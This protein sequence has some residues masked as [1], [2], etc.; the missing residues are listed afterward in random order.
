MNTYTDVQQVSTKLK[1]PVVRR[2]RIL[3]PDQDAQRSSMELGPSSSVRAFVQTVF[4]PTLAEAK[5]ASRRAHYHAL[6]KHVLT[7][8]CVEELVSSDG[9][10][11]KGKLKARTDWPYLDDVR[12]CD[13]TAD[14]VRQL[15]ACASAQGYSPQTVKHIRNVI[16]TIVKQA[17]RQRVFD[18]DNPIHDVELP[19][20]TRR[21]SPE[22]TLEQAKTILRSLKYPERE[23]ALLT[24][25]TGVGV[26][27]ICA[28][29]WKHVNLSHRATSDNAVQ[30]PSRSILVG[31]LTRRDVFGRPLPGK[32]RYIP[33][34]EA[35]VA[36]LVELKER[37][38][39]QDP[40]DFV[41]PSSAEAPQ[42]PLT[43]RSLRLHSIAD[44]LRMP[45]LSW[46]ALKRAHHGLIEQL[47]ISLTDQ[48]VTHAFCSGFLSDGAAL[49]EVS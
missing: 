2:T 1:R 16:S 45:W 41:L 39:S 6:L 31:K 10:R 49:E 35:L 17:K 13:L 8:E 33:V 43:L 27:E 25:C 26:P 9:A 7:P 5:S 4:L 38:R 15:I 18:G 28:L 30:I 42:S 34:T 14:R 44:S 24:I 29:R 32:D 3:T 46:Q 47:R 40:N 19:A 22:L 12:L 11:L 48:L 36:V 21:A 20:M 23:V 37:H